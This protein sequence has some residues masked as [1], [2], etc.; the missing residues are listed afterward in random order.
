MSSQYDDINTSLFGTNNLNRNAVPV[1]D[2][3]DHVQIDN[4]D[5][6]NSNNNNNLNL[7][8]NHINKLFK[9]I[10]IIIVNWDIAT[11][12]S[13]R[14][15]INHH[16]KKVEELFHLVERIL[17]NVFCCKVNKFNNNTSITSLYLYI[18]SLV[19]NGL[20]G[21][22]GS[23]IC[24]SLVYFIHCIGLHA[25]SSSSSSFYSSS[26]SFLSND[27][28]KDWFNNFINIR[29]RVRVRVPKPDPKSD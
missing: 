6:N 19:G 9:L 28:N 2:D 26:P 3:D 18:G 16:V 5:N 7:L 4:N 27:T 14:Q 20:I 11:S 29:V 17:L 12:K 25:A 23:K 10:K 13:F 15:Y 24:S 21:S 1:D 22:R 8:E